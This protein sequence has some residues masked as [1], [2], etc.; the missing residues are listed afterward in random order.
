MSPL[1]TVSV[2]QTHVVVDIATY[3]SPYFKPSLPYSGKVRTVLPLGVFNVPCKVY[4]EEGK[5]WPFSG[6]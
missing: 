4:P 2:F 5:H 3:S 1:T 6:R